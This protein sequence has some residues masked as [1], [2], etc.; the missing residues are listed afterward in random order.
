M[1]AALRRRGYPR[2]EQRQ[3]WLDQF[4]QEYN[5]LRPHEALQMK[6]PGSVWRKSERQYQ[7]N[8]PA[9]EYESGSE[10]VRV[11]ANG[12]LRLQGR[13]WGI[14]RALAG[15]WVQ[16]IRIEHRIL[17][18]YCRTLVRELD[19][20]NTGLSPSFT[21]ATECKGCPDNVV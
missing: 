14:S 10:L 8:P 6:T 20:Q 13:S 7:T 3:D 1:E 11:G 19:F 18:Y 4:R 2:Q 16:L 15:E 9:W 5:H 17:I 12:E 21:F